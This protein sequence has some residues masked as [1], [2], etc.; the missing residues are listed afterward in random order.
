M[1]MEIARFVFYSLF[2]SNPMQ[3]NDA[4]ERYELG[5]LGLE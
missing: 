2:M 1:N 5:Q 3:W 4:Q